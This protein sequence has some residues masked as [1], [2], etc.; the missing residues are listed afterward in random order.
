M[1]KGKRY[2]KTKKRYANFFLFY[3]AVAIIVF[4]NYTFSR[5][6]TK[7]SFSPS[8]GV[9]KFNVKINGVKVDETTSFKIGL[10][11]TQNTYENKLVPDSN[12]YFI[13]N[14]DPTDTEVSL[15]YELHFNLNEENANIKLTKYSVD[16]GA[17]FKTDIEN[18]T[19]K[20]DLILKENS[21]GFTAEDTIQMVVYWDWNDLEDRYNPVINDTSVIVTAR[22][23]PKD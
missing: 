16:N 4:A 7:T 23:K 9:A 2:K 22:C 1:A 14:I 17:T 5:Y 13:I 6:T 11:E 18:N 8:I 19:I 20:G 15:Q 3:M 10:S 12:G 21:K